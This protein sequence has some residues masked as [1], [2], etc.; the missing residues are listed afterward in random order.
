VWG[1]QELSFGHGKSARRDI[2][3]A[4]VYENTEFKAHVQSR[5]EHLRIISI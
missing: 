3:E 4:A 2:W 5:E 1:N